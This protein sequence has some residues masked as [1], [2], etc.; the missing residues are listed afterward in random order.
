MKDY[1]KKVSE[2]S[3]ALAIVLKAIGIGL[4]GLGGLVL[5]HLLGIW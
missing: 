3:L 4:I 1:F 5:G 2:Q